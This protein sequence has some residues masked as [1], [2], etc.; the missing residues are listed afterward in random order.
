MKT[1]K[2]V[3]SPEGKEI[4]RVQAKTIQQAKKK[5][6][7]PWKKYLGEV[8]AEEIPTMRQ[9]TADE[10]A[11][12]CASFKCFG[13]EMGENTLIHKLILGYDKNDNI[14]SGGIVGKVDYSTEPQTYWINNDSPA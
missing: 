14:I 2:L 12:H 3:W 1:F 4:A 6:P 8:Y 11:S 5:T 10:W 7:Q 9:V 13:S